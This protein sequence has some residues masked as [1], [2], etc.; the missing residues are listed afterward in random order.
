MGVI[1]TIRKH[2][3][4]A[5]AIGGIAIIAF[6]IGDLQ[7]N[8]GGIPDMGKID[9]TTI[10]AQHFNSRLEQMENNYKRQQGSRAVVADFG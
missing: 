7:K 5:V 4:V 9:G 1:G 10:T 8:R 6:I 2:S 3:W